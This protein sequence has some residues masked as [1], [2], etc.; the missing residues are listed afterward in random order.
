MAVRNGAQY[1]R[2]AIESV[3]AQSVTDFEFLVVD[4]FSDDETPRLLSEYQR[5]DSSIRVI[6]NDRVLGP[7]PSANRALAQ[8]RGRFI[9][10]H[11]ADDLSPPGRFETQI[12]ALDEPNVSLVTGAIELFGRGRYANGVWRPPSWQPRLEWDSTFFECRW[13]RWPCHVP[14]DTSRGTGSISRQVEVFRGLRPLV[15]VEPAGPRCLPC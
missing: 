10:R 11:D 13:S 8:A 9:A 14:S 4:D 6:R 7:Y 15:Q 12:A 1:V 2:E 3:L 5:I